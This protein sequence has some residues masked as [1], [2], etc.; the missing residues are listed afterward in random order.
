MGLIK[1]KWWGYKL[2]WWVL[3]LDCFVGGYFIFTPPT[4]T[5]FNAY[6]FLIGIG[7]FGFVWFLPNA[8]Y[9]TKRRYLFIP[10]EKESIE[11]NEQLGTN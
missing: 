9:F 3:I 7:I 5:P 8:I 6:V 10:E 11:E 1:R 4:P 2:N